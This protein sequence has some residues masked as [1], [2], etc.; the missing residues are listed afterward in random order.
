MKDEYVRWGTFELTINHVRHEAKL[1]HCDENYSKKF[2]CTLGIPT[3]KVAEIT[4][5]IYGKKVYSPDDVA[6]AGFLKQ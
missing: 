5:N 3:K 2:V 1:S 6:E 4:P